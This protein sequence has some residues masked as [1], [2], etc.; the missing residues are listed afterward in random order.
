[1]KRFHLQL[2]M[3]LRALQTKMHKSY[4]ISIPQNPDSA[5]HFL[6]NVRANASDTLQHSPQNKEAV[7]IVP[8]A[9][10]LFICVGDAFFQFGDGNF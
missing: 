2:C 8:F 1:M 9:L 7:Q 6:A 10:V 4:L 5:K 3:A